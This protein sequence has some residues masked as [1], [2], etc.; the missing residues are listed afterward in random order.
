MRSRSRPAD[1]PVHRLSGPTELLAAVP[2]LLGFQPRDS[3][4]LVGLQGT[5]LVVTARL[6]LADAAQH[7]ALEHAVA[8]MARGGAGSVVAAIYPVDG[9][10]EDWVAF[11]RRLAVIVGEL[12]CTLSDALLVDAGRW[13]SLVCEAA[14]C[15][16]PEG[17]PIDDA[18]SAFAAYATYEGLVVLPDRGAVESLL[19][20]LPEEERRRLGPDL[21]EEERAAVRAVL[22]GQHERRERAIKRALFAAARASDAP[23]APVLA[24]AEVARY[25]VALASTPF[26][27]AVWIAVDAGRLDGRPLWQELARR[28]PPPHDAAPLFLYGWSSW[29]AG[30]GPIAGMAAERAIASDPDYT[31][32][33]LLMAAVTSGLNPHTVP[34]LRRSA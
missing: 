17:R 9:D 2:Y 11:A 27:D 29:R 24:D 18:T 12:G 1:A 21:A 25:G 3:V 6:D 20:P 33:D 30:A 7:G 15:C 34:R 10:A 28:L 14:D 5:R 31:A 23:P 22:S 16:P 32:A 13:R 26:R 4:V 19:E 8:T